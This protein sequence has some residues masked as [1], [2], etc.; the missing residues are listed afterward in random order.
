MPPVT[1][2]MCWLCDLL[3]LRRIKKN[4]ARPMSARPMMGPTTAPAI[5]A[6]LLLFPFSSSPNVEVN[7][8]LELA[9]LVGVAD[10][11]LGT[12]VVN[13]EVKTVAWI[14]KMVF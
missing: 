8:G 6:L 5:Q 12:V 14:S 1:D 2:A 4:A 3:F 13:L 7:V 10:T 9:L 11:R